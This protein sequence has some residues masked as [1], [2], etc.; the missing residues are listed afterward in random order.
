MRP[1]VPTMMWGVFGP[2]SIFFCFSSDSP[3]KITSVRTP[4]RNFDNRVNSPL[5]W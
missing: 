5:I 2:F 3:P 4:G 1:G